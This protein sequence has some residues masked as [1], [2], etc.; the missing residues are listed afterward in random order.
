MVWDITCWYHNLIVKKKTKIH[1]H[2]QYIFINVIK[3]RVDELIYNNQ[4]TV[5]KA[6]CFL[7]TTKAQFRAHN[8]LYTW[9]RRRPRLSKWRQIW[10]GQEVAII[11]GIFRGEPGQEELQT[12]IELG[13]QWLY[14]AVLFC[15][16]LRRIHPSHK[17]QFSGCTSRSI[18]HCE[19]SASLLQS[20]VRPYQC[21]TLGDIPPF[22]LAQQIPESL[23]YWYGHSLLC[24]PIECCRNECIFAVLVPSSGSRWGFL[25]GWNE[26]CGQHKLK[27]FSCCVLQ[28]RSLI[29]YSTYK[30]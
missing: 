18:T 16:G 19:A 9:C 30:L 13:M 23:Y 8:Q 24:Y 17:P 1:V 26:V 6:S 12:R 2:S 29:K 3:N 14:R 11:L 21:S 20:G 15:R 7:F 27:R 5:P 28:P 4:G 22:A 10:P 25:N